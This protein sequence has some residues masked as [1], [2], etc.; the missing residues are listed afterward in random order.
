ML[1]GF[2][3]SRMDVGKVPAHGGH[4]TDL[5][6]PHPELPGIIVHWF[7]TTLLETPDHAP[8]DALAA[9][10]ILNQLQIPGEAATVKAQ[11]LEARKKQPHAQLWPEAAGDIIGGHYQLSGD[12]KNAIEIYQLNLFAY[13]DSP[14]AHGNL[15]DAYLQNGQKALARQLAQEALALLDA[16]KVPLSSWSDTDQRRAEVRRDIEDVLKKTAQ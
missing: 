16:H 14:D 4:G 1:P 7:V 6:Q 3:T 10:S 12:I 5:F 9:A 11:L 2:G 13:P 15:A 8:A